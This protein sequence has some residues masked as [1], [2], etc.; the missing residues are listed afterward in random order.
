MTAAPCQDHQRADDRAIPGSLPDG[1][2]V[3]HCLPIP[4]AAPVLPLSLD[5]GSGLRVAASDQTGEAVHLARLKRPPK[6]QSWPGS[7]RDDDTA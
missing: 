3:F 6:E 4:A 1:A 7:S 5:P 2:C